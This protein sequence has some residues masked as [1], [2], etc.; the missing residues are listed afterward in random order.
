MGL[1]EDSD[2]EVVGK[3]VKEHGRWKTGHGCGGDGIKRGSWI[4]WRDR[5]KTCRPGGE[6]QATISG[7]SI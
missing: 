7:I 3:S 5:L 1:E 2:C 6:V 4:W